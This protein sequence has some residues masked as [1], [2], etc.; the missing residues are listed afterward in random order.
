MASISLSLNLR[1]GDLDVVMKMYCYCDRLKDYHRP[2][3]KDD[4]SEFERAT[5]EGKEDFRI[6]VSRINRKLNKETMRLI[7]EADD[8]CKCLDK[9]PL[10][11]NSSKQSIWI[12]TQKKPHEA[13]FHQ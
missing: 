12:Y 1:N 8:T 4:T 11:R 10:T 5:V 6:K 2:E 7:R 9:L 3:K 13:A